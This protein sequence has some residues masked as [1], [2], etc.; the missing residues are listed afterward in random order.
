MIEP[1]LEGLAIFDP[2]VVE[3]AVGAREDDEDLFFHRKRTVLSLLQDFGQALPAVELGWVA[4]SRS[5]PNWAK[6]VRY[7]TAPGP[8]AACRPP[9][10]WL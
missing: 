3:V 1:L 7:C 6:A 2:Q 10:S 9:A 4:L 8:G 5:L